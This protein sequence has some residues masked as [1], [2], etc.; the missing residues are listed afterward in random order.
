MLHIPKAMRTLIDMSLLH[1]CKDGFIHLFGFLTW[2]G[3]KIINWH[4]I[5]QYNSPA[6]YSHHDP[7]P[8]HTTT[9]HRHND[10]TPLMSTSK[11]SLAKAGATEVNQVAFGAPVIW[12]NWCSI[13]ILKP[14][15]TCLDLK[16]LCWPCHCVGLLIGEVDIRID[17]PSNCMRLVLDPSILAL[18][19]TTNK[20]TQ[21]H[22]QYIP[23][24]RWI[25][26][27][28]CLFPSKS[29]IC[30]YHTNTTICCNKIHNRTL[31]SVSILS[32]DYSLI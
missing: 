13:S 16:R 10:N 6:R 3:R 32:W 15:H 9:T 30:N 25:K 27:E 18:T 1:F 14:R 31:L 7:E 26:I 22:S 19:C 8:Q 21:W 12:A 2:R 11:K 20:P 28:I 17:W 23:S 5:D 29:T 4:N 24:M